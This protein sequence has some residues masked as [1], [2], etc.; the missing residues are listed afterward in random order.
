VRSILDGHVVL[1]RHLAHAGHYPAID[2]LQSVSRLI[3]EVVSPDVRRA[4][5]QLRKL[6]AAFRDKEDLIAIG[7]YQA[8]TDPVVDEAVAKRTAIDAFLQQT[9][10]DVSDAPTADEQ[11]LALTGVPDPHAAEV[12][13]VEQP[14]APVGGESA[15]PPLHLS[16]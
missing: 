4:G 6:L 5:M 14:M 2:V 12:A 15:I 16:V 10:D 11:L 8:G 13:E 7:A 1:S 3:G 9:V